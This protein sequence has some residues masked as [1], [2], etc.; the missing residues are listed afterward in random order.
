MFDIIDSQEGFVSVNPKMLF[1]PDVGYYST[2]RGSTSTGNAGVQLNPFGGVHI[3]NVLSIIH[4][5]F[6]LAGRDYNDRLMARAVFQSR[7]DQ[8]LPLIGVHQLPTDPSSRKDNS[9]YWNRYL[10]EACNPE[11]K[12]NQ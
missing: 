2:V 4:E 3:Q 8:N 7:M 5:V 10:E 12:A 6:H 1:A 9:A 11:L